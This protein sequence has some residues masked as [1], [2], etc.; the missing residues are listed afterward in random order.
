M[1]IW[2]FRQSWQ[3]YRS[4]DWGKVYGQSCNSKTNGRGHKLLKYVTYKSPM[5][6]N[7]LGIHR[8]SKRRTWHSLDG[9]NHNKN[10]YILVRKYFLSDV[11]PPNTKLTRRGHRL[12]PYFNDK[13][14]DLALEGQRSNSNRFIFHLE[15]LKDPA[16]VNA[17]QATTGDRFKPLIMWLRFHNCKLRLSNDWHRQGDH[18][19]ATS[20]K[21]NG[22]ENV[23]QMK[24]LISVMNEEIKQKNE[25]RGAENTEH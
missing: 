17:F 9:N 18:W 1:T 2:L 13:L 12:R 3:G 25:P 11:K 10:D 6:T 20:Q 4:P 14:Q 24:L 21:E 8:L 22:S 15:I 7:T 23:Q 16:D 5:M 19:Q